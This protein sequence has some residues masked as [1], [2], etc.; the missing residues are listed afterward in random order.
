MDSTFCNSAQSHEE[1]MRPCPVDTFPYD[2]SPFG[3]RGLG[4]NSQD[5]CLNDPGGQYAGWRIFRGGYWSEG[6][7]SI[8]ASDRSGGLTTKVTHSFGG[9]MACYPVLSATE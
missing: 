1:G 7:L 9:R 3:V 6:G 4:G 5:K 8:R 2:E